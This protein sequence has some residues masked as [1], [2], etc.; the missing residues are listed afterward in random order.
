MSASALSA[1]GLAFIKREEGLS[2]SRYE[3]PPHSGKYSIG[4]GHSI[5]AAEVADGRFGMTI[6]APAAEMVLRQDVARFETAIRT[7]IAVPL[8]QNQFD[9]LC[10]LV[11]NCGTK[12][13]YETMGR[14]LND[15]DYSGAREV[16]SWWNK[17][18]APLLPDPVLTARRSREAQL[19]ATPDGAGT[20]GT[21]STGVMI[22]VAAAGV[23]LAGILVAMVRHG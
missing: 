11:F 5:T 7:L 8:S 15:G 9:A 21:V 13:L 16:F 12:V 17:S 19:F 6:S 23:I 2:L 3:D 14:R 20:V 22:G 18:G 4:Y 10:S 1:A